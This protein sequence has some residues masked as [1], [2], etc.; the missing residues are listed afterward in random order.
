MGD[1][2]IPRS[3][4]V[5]VTGEGTV[6]GEFQAGVEAG[7]GVSEMATTQG[8]R[9]TQLGTGSPR[10]RCHGCRSRLGTPAGCSQ[11]HP[12][13]AHRCTRRGPGTARGRCSPRGIG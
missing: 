7:D 6:A 12:S 5:A 8:P 9:E 10:H 11:G 4:G 3:D 2:R 13:Q 1:G